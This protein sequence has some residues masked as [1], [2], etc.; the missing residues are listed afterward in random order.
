MLDLSSSCLFVVQQ[1]LLNDQSIDLSHLEHDSSGLKVKS[2]Y[3]KN[4]SLGDYTFTIITSD[5]SF[6]LNLTIINTLR[7]YMVSKS[8]VTS[9]LSSSHTFLFE[10]FGGKIAS[11]SGHGINASNYRISGNLLTINHSFIKD[12]FNNNVTLETMVLAYALEV[13]THTVIGNIFITK[14]L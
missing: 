3:L 8:S 9:D 1:L 5:G 7:P 13:G 10:L 12:T 14:S 11:L 6:V 4:L 2:T